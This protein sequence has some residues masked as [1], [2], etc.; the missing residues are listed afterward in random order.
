MFC[1]VCNV[2]LL[3]PTCDLLLV[4]PL[5]PHKH[6]GLLDVIL[7]V[8][9]ETR[10]PSPGAQHSG[11]HLLTSVPGQPGKQLSQQPSHR[12]PSLNSREPGELPTS[13][14]AGRAGPLPARTRTAHSATSD[15]ALGAHAP[16]AQDSPAVC[17]Q[18]AGIQTLLPPETAAPRYLPPVSTSTCPLTPKT[19]RHPARPLVGPHR[20]FCQEVLRGWSLG[21]PALLWLG[22]QVASSSWGTGRTP[23]CTFL[24][25]TL[26]DV[27]LRSLGV[28][29]LGL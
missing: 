23:L 13:R 12:T 11:C 21:L 7:C 8:H 3:F 18:E 22:L 20:P 27:A 9:P 10:V 24:V 29:P 26:D 16:P 25:V 19:A 17:Y 2:F 4:S 1:D 14:A 5:G 28:E 6:S 15:F